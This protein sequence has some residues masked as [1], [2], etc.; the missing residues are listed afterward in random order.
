M[1]RRLSTME[2]KGILTA[3]QEDEGLRIDGRPLH[4]FRPVTITPDPQTRGLVTVD[5]GHGE[6]KT[7][8]FSTVSATLSRPSIE[9][10]AE[11]MVSFYVE[12]FGGSRNVE[13][14]RSSGGRSDASE[15]VELERDGLQRL[16]ERILKATR[17]LDLES[18]CVVPGEQVWAV[19]VD[20]HV[21][22]AK[23]SLIDALSIAA[24]AS[25]YDFR[26]P[27]VSVD[28][29][30]GA[31]T[32]VSYCSLLNFLSSIN[33]SQFTNSAFAIIQRIVLDISN[34]YTLKLK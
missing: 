28:V 7:K 5:L 8:V 17:I 29:E 11:G 1:V 9:R 14:F 23:G 16:I 20:L 30:T 31:V 25:L 24:V 12:I 6:A 15:M 2:R 27:D 22:Q 13:E 33:Y 10:P 21:L 19:R 32:V 3:L 4:G 18:L 26:R 34:Y